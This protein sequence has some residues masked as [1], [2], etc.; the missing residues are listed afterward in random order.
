VILVL[1]QIKP[2]NNA[3]FY[4]SEIHFNIILPCPS[5]NPQWGLLAFSPKASMHSSL[6]ALMNYLLLRHFSF[7]VSAA[8]IVECSIRLEDDHKCDEVIV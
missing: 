1:S 5:K 4:F 8:E 6:H 7:A 3:A 2:L